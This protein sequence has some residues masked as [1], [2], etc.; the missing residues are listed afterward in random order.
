MSLPAV[1][2]IHR[3]SGEKASEHTNPPAPTIRCGSLPSMRPTRTVPLESPVASSSP[4]GVRDVA[5]EPR[6]A[7][8]VDL[9]HAAGPEK[10]DDLVGS[11][12]GAGRE[13]HAPPAQRPWS[14]YTG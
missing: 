8:A 6:V 4:D 10:L 1:E 13:W 14:P 11:E 2:A 3:P 5:S 7:R 9:P 12:T